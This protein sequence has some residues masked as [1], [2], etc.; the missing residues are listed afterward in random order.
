MKDDYNLTK[1]TLE[2]ED[3]LLDRK[4]AILKFLSCFD[5]QILK[6]TTWKGEST[7]GVFKFFLTDDLEDKQIIS[8]PFDYGE[9]LLFDTYGEMNVFEAGEIE[10]IEVITDPITVAIFE[11]HE[12]I[13]FLSSKR[14]M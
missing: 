7:V 14:N 11:E 10:M 12:L 1:L 2:I 4:E 6:V 3:L 9:V 13:S 5:K 8:T